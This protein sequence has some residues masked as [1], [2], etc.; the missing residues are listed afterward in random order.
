MRSRHLL[1]PEL[2]EFRVV[3]GGPFQALNEV[4]RI[5]LLPIDIRFTTLDGYKE[6]INL[7]MSM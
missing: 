6:C 2:R 7:A 4:A 3:H 1:K 5:N